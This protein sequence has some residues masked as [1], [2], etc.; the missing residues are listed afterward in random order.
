MYMRTQ[1]GLT[2]SLVFAVV[3][4]SASAATAGASSPTT[5][6]VVRP[7]PDEQTFTA[8]ATH[9]AGY[10]A[11]SPTVQPNP[12]EQA[13]ITAPQSTGPHSEVIDNRGYGFS[14]APATIV[15]VTAPDGFD[16]ADA[17]VGAV[18]GFALSIIA[19]AGVVTISQRR[20]RRTPEPA[21]A[22]N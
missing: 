10:V 12:D 21:D 13:A 15:R 2:A 22:T 11:A 5:R 6:P 20:G 8:H 9:V 1:Q 4:V 16:W 17:G 19:V 18:G 7:N 3:L 14:N